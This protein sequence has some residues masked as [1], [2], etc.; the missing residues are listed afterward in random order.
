MPPLPQLKELSESAIRAI[1]YIDET[2]IK[3]N[4][5]IACKKMQKAINTN[6]K[7]A[8][9]EIFKNKNAQPR[10]GLQALR[11]PET[12]HIETEPTKQAQIV[13][14]YYTKALMAVN[15]KHGKYLPHEAPLIYPW[16]QSNHSAPVPDP[17]IL[18]S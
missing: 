10:T 11:D 5:I 17:F 7:Q 4:Y 18:Q 15:I 6:P 14:I 13:E 2:R 12:G 1:T 9:K 16:E 3:D 8:H